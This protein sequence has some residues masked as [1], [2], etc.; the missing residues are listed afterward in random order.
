MSRPPSAT[1]EEL[2]KYWEYRKTV[3]IGDVLEIYIETERMPPWGDICSE[4]PWMRRGV[5][6]AFRQK[7]HGYSGVYRL[8]GLTIEG[9]V[10]TP[11]IITR[12]HG[13]DTTG[14]LYIGKAGQL[15]QRL[16]QFRRSL[17]REMSHEAAYTYR[18]SRIM[19]EKFPRL[20]FAMLETPANM[21]FGVEQDLIRAYLNS[22][23]DSPPLNCSF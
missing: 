13:Q 22:F 3:K 19:Q 23:G 10:G 20:A 2:E 16:N 17:I 4:L 15:H 21:A 7:V 11:A 1:V 6:T 14:T 12:L 18:E 8:V 9:D 5:G